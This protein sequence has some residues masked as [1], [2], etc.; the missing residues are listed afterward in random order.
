[1]EFIQPK[2]IQSPISGEPVRP[3]LRTYIRG[4][5]E[6]VEAQY[7]DPASGSFIRK[8]VVSVKEIKK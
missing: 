4:N 5:Q 8:G 6:I 7:I 2:I 3:T 1:M